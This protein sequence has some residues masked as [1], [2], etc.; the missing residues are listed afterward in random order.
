[1][2]GLTGTAKLTG[3]VSH[4][5]SRDTGLLMWGLTGTAPRAGGHQREELGV[6]VGRFLIE[7]INETVGA[8]GVG[9]TLQNVF[10]L[11][12]GH[13]HVHSFTVSSTCRAKDAPPH[14]LITVEY[15][16]HSTPSFV[17][18]LQ[19]L[20]VHPKNLR[21]LLLRNLP[22]NPQTLRHV[23]RTWGAHGARRVGILVT[24]VQDPTL[25]QLRDGHHTGQCT[26]THDTP[27]PP[28]HCWGW[29]APLAVRLFLVPAQPVVDPQ[30][31]KAASCPATR[32][33]PSKNRAQKGGEAAS[34]G[35]HCSHDRDDEAGAQ[36][37]CTDHVG[38][39]YR[40]CHPHTGGP[41]GRAARRQ[42]IGTLAAQHLQMKVRLSRQSRL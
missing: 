31:R 19:Q 26:H 17:I 29:R 14:N 28:L 20:E 11:L 21:S 5:C 24:D 40:G 23:L 12:P 38:H 1:M 35:T 32:N 4:N 34:I 22:K 42:D 16:G 10:F 6:G 33:D 9:K 41:R 7:L 3:Q 18:R 39:R 8:G 2:W 27:A 15:D 13:P 25:E 37:R 30:A 36:L